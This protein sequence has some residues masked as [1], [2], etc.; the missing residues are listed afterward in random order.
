MG[1]GWLLGAIAAW[2]AL[3]PP[4]ARGQSAKEITE[5]TQ[6]WWSLNSTT[7][8]SDRFGAIGDV[9]VRRTDFVRD[10]SF[11]F[12]RLGAHYWVT[13][14]FTVSLGYAH[15]W[16]APSCEGCETWSNENRVY[17]QAQY[18]TMLGRT[19]VL[20]RVRSEQRFRQ[21]VENDALTGETAFS[22]RVRFLASFTIPVSQD[23]SGLAL[24]LSDEVLLQFGAGIVVNTFDQNRLFAGIKKQMSRSWGF[25]FGY[26]LV[27]QQKSTG[28]QYDLNHTLRWFLYWTPDLRKVKTAH[29]T[30]G[31]EE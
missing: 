23:A 2:C 22:D 14:K 1:G 25:D 13:E 31:S 16:Q 3:M 30:A 6:F 10:P 4:S 9:H 5:Q 8:L 17:E 12:L 29:E 18:A 20:H 15:M 24:V 27:Y 26:M 19:R 11:Y 7:R 21:V 28:Y